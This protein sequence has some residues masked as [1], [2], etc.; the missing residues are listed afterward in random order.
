[1]MLAGGIGLIGDSL[2]GTW[3]PRGYAGTGN[4]VRTALMSPVNSVGQYVGASSSS[5]VYPSLGSSLLFYMPAIICSE[6]TLRGR[7][8]GVYI[9]LNNHATV[10]AG[11]EIVNP[12]GFTGTLVTF[13]HFCTT[14]G[15]TATN[16]GH[17]HI[18]KTGA[19][20]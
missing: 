4:P 13:R 7:M 3:V 5:M 10:A 20:T 14:N 2:Q 8:R 15:N 11:T 19:W 1:M 9:P 16:D 6:G 17:F 18:D 12:P